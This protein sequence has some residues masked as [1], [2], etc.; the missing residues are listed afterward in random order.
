MAL[1]DVLL[2][3]GDLEVT[4]RVHTSGTGVGKAVHFEQA[5][6]PVEAASLVPIVQIEV[7][8]EAAHR[9]RRLIRA[10]MKAAVDP[11]ADQHHILAVL[12]GGHIAVLDELPHFLHL[13]VL[14]VFFE[15]GV[16]LLPFDLRKLHRLGSLSLFQK[17][18]ER[19]CTG[20]ELPKFSATVGFERFRLISTRY[21]LLP[22]PIAS[23]SASFA[24]AD[25]TSGY[26]W[27]RKK[28]SS[29]TP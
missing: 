25:S 19:S 10:Q 12:I 4:L 8:Q 29:S 20:F 22:S 24:L 5:A 9:Q 7:M 21:C 17:Y 15:D 13:G 18:Q 28:F 6:Q 1:D 11:K 2:L 14:V 3:L 27:I 23:S 16:K 26:H